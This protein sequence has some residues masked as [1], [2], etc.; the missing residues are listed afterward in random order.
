MIFKIEVEDN[1]YLKYCK[2]LE[3]TF[4]EAQIKDP[5]TEKLVFQFILNNNLA[6]DEI[7]IYHNED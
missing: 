4:K 1:L 2:F 3:K 7:K 5:I 6:N